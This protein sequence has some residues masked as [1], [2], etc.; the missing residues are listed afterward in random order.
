MLR[1]Q[2]PARCLSKLKGVHARRML[3]LRRLK[4][5]YTLCQVTVKSMVDEG[6]GLEQGSLRRWRLIN[7][8]ATHNGHFHANVFD[9]G[10]RNL[11]E[12][13]GENHKVS[14]PPR[15]D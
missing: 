6:L 14:K 12:I 1:W 5:N 4:R 9:P 8:I 10:R 11:E 15:C 2:D 13:V 7:Y 3:S